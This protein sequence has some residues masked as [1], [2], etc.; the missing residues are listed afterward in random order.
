MPSCRQM[1]QICKSLPCWLVYCFIETTL[2]GWWYVDLKMIKDSRGDCSTRYMIQVVKQL[3]QVK[4]NSKTFFFLYDS[5]QCEEWIS[6]LP[7]TWKKDWSDRVTWEWACEI[8]E[9]PD[10]IV[11]YDPIPFIEGPWVWASA[12][13]RL[14]ADCVSCL[15][16]FSD[17]GLHDNREPISQF[18]DVLFGFLQRTSTVNGQ[19]LSGNCHHGRFPPQ[20]LLPIS[21]RHWEAPENTSNAGRNRMTSGGPSE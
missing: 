7:E 21:D 16:H 2:C 18:Y 11:G 17:I 13:L 6:T 8:L 3:K 20:L 10:L 5:K 15:V 1:Y 12:H 19:V 9:A 14:T 4:W